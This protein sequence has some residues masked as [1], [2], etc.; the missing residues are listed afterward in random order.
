MD[1][2]WSLDENHFLGLHLRAGQV[3]SPTAPID[4][5]NLFAGRLKQMTALLDAVGTK[6]QH[7]VV[8][9]ERGVGKTSLVSILGS[10]AYPNQRPPATYRQ[11]CHREDTFPRIW[12]RAFESVTFVTT[13]QGAGFTPDVEHRVANVAVRLS[14]ATPDDVVKALREL[15]LPIVFIFDEF[16]QLTDKSVSHSFSEVIKALS[17]YAVRTTIILVGVGDDVD[18]LIASHASVE[19]AIR[20]VHMPRMEV[21]ER[22]EIIDKAMGELGCACAPGA[23]NRIVR[24]SQGLPHFVHSLGLHSARVAFKRRSTQIVMDDVTG[25]I[26]DALENAQQS[27][28]DAYL[29]ATSSPHKESLYKY[30]LLACAMAVTDELGY[31]TPAAI[32]Q[33]LKV[34]KRPLEIPAFAGHLNKFASDDRGTVLQKTGTNRRFRYRFGNPLLQPFVLMRG[35]ADG[36]IPADTLDEV[37]ATSRQPAGA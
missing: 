25:G 19:R 7:A 21:T 1:D 11:N 6:G 36:L 5:R 32:R 31:F 9:G 4:Q 18:A 17:D 24:L 12:K 2:A 20:Q 29:K 16:D 8:Y 3:F 10:V 35:I 26:G 27:Q 23:R 37:A 28:I 33:P 22:A 34:M 15:D 13:R 30:V 14:S